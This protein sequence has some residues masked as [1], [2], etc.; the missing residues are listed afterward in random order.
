MVSGGRAYGDDVARLLAE[1]SEAPEYFDWLR[2]IVRFA[3]MSDQ[4]SLFDS[5]LAAMRHGA[6]D[7][8][9]HELWLSVHDLAAKQPL[10]AIELL[11]A[12]LVDRHDALTLDE[13]G[14][15][16]A[17]KVHDYSA[18]ELVRGAATAEPEAF[19]A[20]IVPYLQAVMTATEYRPTEDGPLLDRHFHVRLLDHEAGDRDLDDVLYGCTAKALERLAGA[21]PTALLPTLQSLADDP[22]EAAQY[23]LFRALIAAGPALADWAAELLLEGGSR[24]ECGYLS[25]GDWVSREVV[26]AIAPPSRTKCMAAW[27]ELSQGSPQSVRAVGAEWLGVIHVH[28]CAGGGSADSVLARAGSRNFVASSRLRIRRR[29]AASCRA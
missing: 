15:V 11:E 5:M 19:A 26:R 3:H 16:A 23:L 21:D 1:Q 14:Q 8:S 25:D 12:R 10:W 18:A 9:G 27:R 29:L 7:D 22:H 28:V 17:L 24:L 4:R 2:W 6:F 13:A 20:A